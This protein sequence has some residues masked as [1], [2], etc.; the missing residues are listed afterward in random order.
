MGTS[1]PPF[2]KRFISIKVRFTRITSHPRPF[3]KELSGLKQMETGL[4]VQN[5]DSHAGEGEHRS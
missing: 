5:N 4:F 2:Y 1:S 3:V